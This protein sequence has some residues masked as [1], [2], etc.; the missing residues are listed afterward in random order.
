MDEKEQW[1]GL[2]KY[3][4]DFSLLNE[5]EVPDLVLWEKYLVYATTFGIAEKVLNQLKVRYPEFSDENY[6]RNTAYFYIMM[7]PGYNTTFV[8]SI[9]TSVSRAYSASVAASNSSS[10]GGYGGG[11]SGRRR[12]PEAVEAG[13][14]GR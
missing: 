11:F 10:G 13:G 2:K 5:K 3:M 4:D 6:M 7:H 9:N 8:N 12:W 1:Q 14:G